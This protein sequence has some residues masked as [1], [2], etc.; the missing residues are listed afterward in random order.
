MV[1]SLSP[2]WLRLHC[3]KRL[4]SE[5]GSVSGVR[6]LLYSSKFLVSSR[7]STKWT[8]LLLVYSVGVL[9]LNHPH[10]IPIKSIHDYLILCK[11]FYFECLS[12]RSQKLYTVV[13][14]HIFDMV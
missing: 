6:L 5:G 12:H 8:Y 2:I 4:L 11:W 7:A 10:C 9:N 13:P 1:P 14:T 3:T